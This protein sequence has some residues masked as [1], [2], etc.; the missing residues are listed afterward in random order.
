M[1]EPNRS[2]DRPRHAQ[3]LHRLL[4]CIAVLLLPIAVCCGLSQLSRYVNQYDDSSV[5][6]GFVDAL[7]LNDARLAK[8]LVIPEQYTRIDRWITEHTTVFA[9]PFNWKFW[10]KD[11][12]EGEGGGGVGSQ[13]LA[14]TTVARWSYGYRCYR[15]GY[16]FH[17]DDMTLKQIGGA[18]HVVDWGEICESLDGGSSTCQR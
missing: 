3:K 9:C 13:L 6:E 1:Q 11:F 5:A 17:V 8:A 2:I 18:W 15:A 14:D 4:G 10:E 12:W 7:R 16:S